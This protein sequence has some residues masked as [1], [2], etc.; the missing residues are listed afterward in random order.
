MAFQDSSKAN[1]SFKVLLGRT[2]TGNDKELAN[3]SIPSNPVLSAQFIWADEINETPGDVANTNIVSDL[4]T[5]ELDA[6]ANGISYTARLGAAVPASLA[7]RIN[8]LTGAVYAA[9]DRVG[10]IIPDKFGTDFRPILRDNG[11]EVPP[12]DSSDWFLDPFAGVV[13]QEN[14]GDSPPLDLGTTGTLDCYI[15]IG[16]FVS[17]MTAASNIISG[18]LD[19]NTVDSAYIVAH[20]PVAGVPTPVATIVAPTSGDVVFA[21]QLV[22][23]QNDQFTVVLSDTPEVSGY[24]INWINAPQ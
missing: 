23:V 12:L 17:D 10:H 21:H 13:V 11:T 22:N 15:Y 18:T 6:E 19:M 3:E 8:P 5:L 16:E 9:F 14:D 24:K 1:F 4:V 2:H 20:A 7:G